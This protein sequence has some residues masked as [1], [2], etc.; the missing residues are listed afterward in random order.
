MGRGFEAMRT[1]R[2]ALPLHA[3]VALLMLAALWLALIVPL[4][5]PVSLHPAVVLL[6]GGVN[7]R[8]VAVQQSLARVPQ[9]PILADSAGGNVQHHSGESGRGTI[10]VTSVPPEMQLGP[11]P[12]NIAD[13]TL[14][15]TAGHR[16]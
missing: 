11:A 4:G 10:E 9:A 7:L 12:Q 13:N 8:F 2:F 6:H 5:T 3:Q 1:P 16:K 15:G 14:D